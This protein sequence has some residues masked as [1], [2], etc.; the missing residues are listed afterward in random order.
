MHPPLLRGRKKCLLP[1]L[2]FLHCFGA[3][4]FT[5][6]VARAANCD[7]Y[8]IAL[9]LRSLSNVPPGAVVSD[10]LNG[11]QPG[12]FGWLSWGGSPSEPTLVHSLTPPGDG[13]T[14]E[15]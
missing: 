12:S 1:A 15:I 8:P 11:S 4:L 9:S 10:I 6:G 7:L 5:R 14:Y 13:A 2:V 3:A